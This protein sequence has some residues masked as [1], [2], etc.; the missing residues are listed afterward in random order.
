MTGS[1][2]IEKGNGSPK[3]E[4]KGFKVSFVHYDKSSSKWVPVISLGGELALAFTQKI[5][6]SF[7]LQIFASEVKVF[8]EKITPE[9]KFYTSNKFLQWK[10]PSTSAS[11]RLGLNF[12]SSEDCT[13]L[14]NSVQSIIFFLKTQKETVESSI[15][16]ISRKQSYDERAVTSTELRE[17]K[18][19]SDFLF[20]KRTSSD[21]SEI[22]ESSSGKSTPRIISSET[23]LSSGR[24]NFTASSLSPPNSPYSTPKHQI[25]EVDPNVT[26]PTN[27]PRHKSFTFFKS[28][29]TK[30]TQNEKVRPAS[31]RNPSVSN[32]L[33]L[34]QLSTSSPTNSFIS[35]VSFPSS[36]PI[37][38]SPSSSY[39]PTDENDQTLSHSQ[40]DSSSFSSTSTNSTTSSTTTTTS[41]PTPS[42]APKSSIT[43]TSTDHSIPVI[44]TSSS[45]SPDR[46]FR[47][48]SHTTLSY[49]S[50]LPS[51]P[52][53]KSP[54]RSSSQS[55]STTSNKTNRPR[56]PKRDTDEN[57]SLEKTKCFTCGQL[58][59]V[60]PP[61]RKIHSTPS[62]N[63]VA[64]PILSMSPPSSPKNEIKSSLSQSS[65]GGGG[66]SNVSNDL[67]QKEKRVSAQRVHALSNT[68]MRSTSESNIAS[69]FKSFN[70]QSTSNSTSTSESK[71]GVNSSGSSNSCTSSSSSNS[72]SSLGGSV[73]KDRSGIP[74]VAKSF[75]KKISGSHIEFSHITNSISSSS[76]TPSILSSN[77]SASNNLSSSSSSTPNSS[78]SSSYSFLLTTNL[79]SVGRE[80]KDPHDR[81]DKPKHE[82]KRSLFP[83]KRNEMHNYSTT[84]ASSGRSRGNTT[85]STIRP[86]RRVTISN[87]DENEFQTYI[88]SVAVGEFHLTQGSRIEAIYPM[89]VSYKRPEYLANLCFPEGAH[90]HEED[91]TYIIL[92]DEYYDQSNSSYMPLYGIGFYGRKLDPNSTR[93]AVQRA[94]LILSF[95]P[96]FHLYRKCLRLGLAEYFRNPDLTVLETLYSRLN[97][98]LKSRNQ[99]LTI[100]GDVVPMS[101]PHISRDVDFCDTSII[102]LINQFGKKTMYLWYALMSEKRILIAS[103][104]SSAHI[105]GNWCLSIPLLVAPLRGFA[106]AITP[107]LTI[108]DTSPLERPFYICATTNPIFE[109]RTEMWDIFVRPELS[110]FVH[111][112]TWKIS[113]EDKTFIKWIIASISR[114]ESEEWVRSQFK[115]YT[116]TFMEK[117]YENRFDKSKQQLFSN[118]WKST[119]F[120]SYRNHK[121]NRVTSRLPEFLAERT[122]E[123]G[124]V[125]KEYLHGLMENDPEV[126]KDLLI[127]FLL[128]KPNQET[129]VIHD[130]E[131]SKTLGRA[132]SQKSLSRL[133]DLKS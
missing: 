69:F 9:L 4:T 58:T 48:R 96:Y 25:L 130:D 27:S 77:N 122:E 85:S 97:D 78:S 59:C 82:R 32:S 1:S 20:H 26:S 126:K 15:Q 42:S 72:N 116:K 43:R 114:G 64:Y 30:N 129:I 103:R 95:K 99:M 61:K 102:S 51:M 87:S 93:N 94:L 105:I 124:K 63:H 67:D 22:Q 68:R 62:D 46:G 133:K 21:A 79:P 113:R 86:P 60:C 104:D 71:F 39:F 108:V 111:P 75:R 7:Y 14:F 120:I 12:L 112:L 107:Y 44:A 70:P 109:S 98:C 132:S 49:T 33:T 11:V 89:S 83:S 38:I 57:T 19:S 41:I 28:P 47:T 54:T 29:R 84:P 23:N 18:N 74:N 101:Y 106:D 34:N 123:E 119:L 110:K 31:D 13:T 8:E 45:E 5:E 53:S 55:S 56:S 35:S 128:R 118:F 115:Y 16:A 100:W 36:T 40:T 65:G 37:S 76:T 90:L 73:F 17:R 131:D 91:W 127:K 2:D 10:K 6:N 3:F 80:N 24:D 52:R 117:L 121:I 50:L 66:I 81:S 125:L 88:H 92:H